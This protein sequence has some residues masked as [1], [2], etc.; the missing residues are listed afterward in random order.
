MVGEW[1]CDMG[2]QVLGIDDIMGFE[3]GW[4]FHA[5]G[6]VIDDLCHWPGTNPFHSEFGS[7]FHL[8]KQ[9]L[10]VASGDPY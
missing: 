5:D 6:I 9:W 2:L 1:I 8:E 7:T 4:E 3:V 10:G